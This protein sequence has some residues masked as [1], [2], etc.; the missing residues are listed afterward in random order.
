LTGLPSSGKTTLAQALQDRLADQ[1]VSVQILDSDQMR[2]VLTPDP[3][4]SADERDWFYDVLAF[5]ASL[6]TQNHV[7]VLIAA[8]APRRAHRQAARS[9]IDRLI[10]VHVD[11]PIEVCR[12]R[13]PKGLWKKAEA[14]EI[15]RLPGAGAPYEPPGSPDVRINTAEL[16]PQEAARLIVNHLECRH[17]LGDG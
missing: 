10:E 2:D 7:N 3:S 11:C 13:D 14:G 4:Y 12:S 16:A 6:L 5:V 9:Q 1:G 17:F 15:T 8:T